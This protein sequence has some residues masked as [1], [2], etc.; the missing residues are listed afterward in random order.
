MFLFVFVQIFFE[1]SCYLWV[2]H[3]LPIPQTFLI[4]ESPVLHDPTPSGQLSSPRRETNSHENIHKD[5]TKTQN[6][7]S[8]KR[9]TLPETNSSHLKMDGWKISFRTTKGIPSGFARFMQPRKKN[10]TGTLQRVDVCIVDDFSTS[11]FPLLVFL[12]IPLFFLG[13]PVKI[14][15][16]KK[17]NNKH[18]PSPSLQE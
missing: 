11:P 17:Q 12:G 18:R 16:S 5:M 15:N 9:H 8:S 14:V 2:W 10:S 1:R 3:L 6:H 13:D 7:N 4:L